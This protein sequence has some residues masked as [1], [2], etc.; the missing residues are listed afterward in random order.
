MSADDVSEASA[1]IAAVCHSLDDA[2]MAGDALRAAG[3]FTPDA[4]LGESGVDDVVGRDAI[5]AFLVRG[6][7]LR[8]VT[9]H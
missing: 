8:T 9:H 5:L 1:A 2:L 3:H 6:N 7:E 4:I